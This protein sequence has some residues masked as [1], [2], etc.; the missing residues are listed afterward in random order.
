MFVYCRVL[1]C[2]ISQ[3]ISFTAQVTRVAAARGK[4]PRL[5]DQVKRCGVDVNDH[6]LELPSKSDYDQIDYDQIPIIEKTI[7]N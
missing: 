1:V 6:G 2:Q 3:A 7:D 5:Q 4:D